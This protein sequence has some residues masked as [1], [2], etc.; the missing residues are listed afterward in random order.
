MKRLDHVILKADNFHQAVDDFRNAGFNVLYGSDPTIAHNA[1]IYLQDNSFIELVNMAKVPGYALWLTR[2][3]VFALMN[4]F[5]HR[6][7][8]WVIED[9]PIFDYVIYSDA[10]ET[11]HSKVSSQSSKLS[12]GRRTN[13]MGIE[14][15]WHYFAP[16]NRQ[17][18]FVISDYIPRKLPVENA[19][20]H[21]NDARGIT[22]LSIAFT[23]EPAAMKAAVMRYYDVPIERVADTDDGFVVTTDNAKLHYRRDTRRWGVQSIHIAYDGSESGSLHSYGI[24]RFAH[25]GST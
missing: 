24:N 8:R 16:N 12:V 21:Q 1:L 18:P 25:E 17:L 3:G 22:A 19:A 9:K 20:I 10:I 5:F 23:G 13:H 15:Q 6:M 7:G 4:S 11:F 2:I 14:V